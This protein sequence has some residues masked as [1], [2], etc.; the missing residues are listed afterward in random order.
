MIPEQVSEKKEEEKRKEE[1]E[2][3]NKIRPRPRSLYGGLGTGMLEMSA[4][5]VETKEKGNYS[6]CI[7]IQSNDGTSGGRLGSIVA[8]L[9]QI[10]TECNVRVARS[11]LDT[12]A[13]D[14]CRA[15]IFLWRQVRPTMVITFSIFL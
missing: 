12:D 7:A 1:K 8:G 15:S 3:E 9:L 4:G 13:N 10:D 5:A 14:N 2:K 11:K 6:S